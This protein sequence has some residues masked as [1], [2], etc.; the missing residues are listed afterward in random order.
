MGATGDINHGFQP[1][2]HAAS[3]DTHVNRALVREIVFIG[4]AHP[5]PPKRVLPKSR[6]MDSVPYNCVHGIQ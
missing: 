4:C 3:S 6:K 5:L 2:N 1:G